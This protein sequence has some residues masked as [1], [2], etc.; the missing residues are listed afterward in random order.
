MAEPRHLLFAERSDDV[1]HRAPATEQRVGAV[2]SGSVERIPADRI[3]CVGWPPELR[4]HPRD[5]DYRH[6]S[7]FVRECQIVPRRPLNLHACLR[8]PSS[9]PER[10]M[11]RRPVVCGISGG[12]YSMPL[13]VIRRSLRCVALTL[14]LTVA[15]FAMAQSYYFPNHLVN[16]FSTQSAAD[17]FVSGLDYRQQD[18]ASVV[19]FPAIPDDAY[20]WL[21]PDVATYAVIW[22]PSSIDG[23]CATDGSSTTLP[24]YP[25]IAIH[26]ESG[27]PPITLHT[28]TDFESVSFSSRAAALSYKAGLTAQ[29][30]STAIGPLRTISNARPW[31]IVRQTWTTLE[32]P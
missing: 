20:W 27:H 9:L 24:N 12:G 7:R 19:P 10:I 17:S 6:H 4:H 29:E 15:P 11:L 32:C 28:L 8:C 5:L 26:C 21:Q 14:C 31:L 2:R 1:G 13:M 25:E 18:R 3:P 30:L 22:Q 23:S 16:S